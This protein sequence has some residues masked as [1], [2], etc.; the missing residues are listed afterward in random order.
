[1]SK[2][3]TQMIDFD[4]D[5]LLARGGIDPSA[6]LETIRLALRGKIAELDEQ[7]KALDEE[8]RP[9]RG[10][11]KRVISGDVRRTLRLMGLA[12]SLHELGFKPQPIVSL[13]RFAYQ[14]EAILEKHGQLET[15]L[16]PHR[17]ERTIEQ[18]IWRGISSLGLDT[19]LYKINP[20]EFFV[21]CKVTLA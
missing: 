4:F 19:D 11:P 21:R 12:Q 13:I 2:T 6:N 10:A 14:A 8:R 5:K 15:R 16:F 20:D 1:M 9:K 17:G 3:D 7:I 18:S